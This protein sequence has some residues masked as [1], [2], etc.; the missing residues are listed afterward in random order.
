MKKHFQDIILPLT[1]LSG[2]QWT[3]ENGVAINDA[4]PQSVRDVWNDY[5]KVRVT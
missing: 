5:T 2:I 4:T 3:P 1:R